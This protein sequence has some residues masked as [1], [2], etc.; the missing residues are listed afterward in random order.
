MTTV[1]ETSTS[2]D[3]RQ[4]LLALL[5]NLVKDNRYRDCFQA[6]HRELHCF[7][8]GLKQDE[9]AKTFVQ[10]LLFDA[11]G[12][13]PHS[14]EI[15]EL[16]QELQLAGVLSR[17]NPTYRYNEITVTDWS[18]ATGFRRSLSPKQEEVFSRIAEEFKERLGVP[19]PGGQ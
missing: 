14:E 9:E 16:L 15:D 18:S 7:F 13:Y 17:P 3:A 2:L 4:F 5:A 10:D 19:S 6:A 1:V 8:W 12:N 11:N